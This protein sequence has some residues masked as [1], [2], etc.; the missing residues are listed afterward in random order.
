MIT[1]GLKKVGKP[2][3]FEEYERFTPETGLEYLGSVP[4]KLVLK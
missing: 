2:V 3:A 4:T 1:L